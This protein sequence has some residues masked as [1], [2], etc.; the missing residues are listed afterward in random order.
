MSPP[1]A[2]RSRPA[3]TFG[4]RWRGARAGAALSR[5][6]RAEPAIYAS[7]MSES[8]ETHDDSQ[9]VPGLLSRAVPGVVAIF[10]AGRPSSRSVAVST[11]G[12]E[13]GRGAPPELLGEDDR[14]SR[15]HVRIARRDG[16]WIVTDLETRNGTFV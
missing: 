8:D 12:I 6:V 11:D 15:R 9:R 1:P 7:F 5:G 14:V 16:E 3:A 10:S 2:R 13:I 4:T